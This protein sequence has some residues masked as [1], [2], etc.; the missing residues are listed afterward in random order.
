MHAVVIYKKI[1]MWCLQTNSEYFLWGYS[2]NQ[3]DLYY[4][5]FVASI[6]D[7]QDINRFYS[8]KH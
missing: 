8:I 4:Y 6:T 2:V 7:R 1:K 5:S 3:M